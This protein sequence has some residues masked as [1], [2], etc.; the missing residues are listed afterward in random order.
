MRVCKVWQ[1]ISKR[2]RLESDGGQ[3]NPLT[4]GLLTPGTIFSE[5]WRG[6]RRHSLLANPKPHA[7]RMC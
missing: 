1:R 6:P 2:I 5:L 4:S 7:D 3:A